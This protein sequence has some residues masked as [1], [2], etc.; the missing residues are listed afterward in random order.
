MRFLKEHVPLGR[1]GKPDEIARVVLFL[2]S[3]AADYMTGV[4]IPVEGGA[5]L[6]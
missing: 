1:M 5:L 3:A 2:V 4:L 6:A